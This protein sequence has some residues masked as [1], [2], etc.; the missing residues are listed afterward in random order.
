MIAEIIEASLDPKQDE[1]VIQQYI[2]QETR[3]SMEL[4]LRNEDYVG[5]ARSEE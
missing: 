3:K 2:D 4:S 1:I 5:G